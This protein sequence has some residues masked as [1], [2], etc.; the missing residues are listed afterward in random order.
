MR[1]TTHTRLSPG[2]Q[3]TKTL[4]HRYQATP[5]CF[6]SIV[7]ALL[8]RGVKTIACLLTP[9]LSTNSLSIS[10]LYSPGPVYFGPNCQ[11]G[12]LLRD[13]LTPLSV[14]LSRRE[15]RRTGIKVMR[16]QHVKVRQAS[17][18]S[19][20]AQLRDTLSRVALKTRHPQCTR[21]LSSSVH[22]TLS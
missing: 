6:F 8:Q 21:T 1:P 2:Y 14:W 4:E 3:V 5:R 9:I 15:A 11:P 18:G 13:C 20:R 10:V 16:C 7:L 19:L 12:N 17:E 22:L